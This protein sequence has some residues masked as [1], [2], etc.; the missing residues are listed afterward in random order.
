MSET[1]RAAAKLVALEPTLHAQ[2]A[3]GLPFAQSVWMN[4]RSVVFVFTPITDIEDLNTAYIVSFAESDELRFRLEEAIWIGIGLGAM[5][6][7][8]W[9]LLLNWIRV[10]R[11]KEASLQFLENINDAM[12]EG[13]YVVD[14]NGR[15]MVINA[16]ALA[17]L[18]LKESD[19]I[20]RLALNLFLPNLDASLLETA[21]E[22]E[23]RELLNS[24]VEMESLCYSEKAFEGD[25]L[26]AT[27][28]GKKFWVHLSSQPIYM[29]RKFVGKVLVFHDITVEKS[30]KEQLRVAAAAFETHEGI[31]ITDAKMNIIRVNKAFTILTGY[32]PEDIIGKTPAALSSGR[33]DKAFYQAMWSTLD[34]EKAWQGEIWNR[35]KNGDFFLESLKITAVTNADGNV[36]EY[37][38][39]FSDITEQ[40]KAQDEII[41][42]A[43]YD[44]LTLLPNR[45]LLNE[46]LSHALVTSERN[47][48]YGAL[49]FI[50]LDNFKQLNDTRGHSAGDAL[51]E[52]VAKRLT[53]T[54]RDVDTVARL[55]GDE[56]VILLESL[57]STSLEA[58]TAVELLVFKILHAFEEVFCLDSGEQ[59]STPSLGV[60]IF[61]GLTL[62]AEQV[63]QH[64]DVAMYQAKQSGRNTACY[65]DPEMQRHIENVLQI[66]SDL[67][68]DQAQGF[69]QLRLYYQPQVD[70]QGNTRSVEALIRWV[71]PQKGLIPPLEFI[72]IIEQNGQIIAVGLWVIREACLQLA[73][74][75]QNPAT[76][77]LAI[78]VN[79]SAKQLAYADFITQ[80]RTVLEET[81]ARPSHL[82]IELT[83]SSVIENVEAVIKV[84]QE[85]CA[86]G[87]ELSM[88]D[89][90][91]GYSSLSYLKRLPLSQLKIDQAFVRD[92]ET[93]MDSL[94]IVQTIIAMAKTLKLIV[95]AEGVETEGQ[96]KCLEA[97]GCELYQGYYFSR[98]LPLDALEEH[99]GLTGH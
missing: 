87:L 58:M 48:N 77:H 57:G 25:Y 41:R 72:P 68:K 23:R 43:F 51:L 1:M 86:L 24:R 13:M 66:E 27:A 70:Y 67:H 49:I 10:S 18:E 91:T 54:V 17:F 20:G 84:M 6:L 42:L 4:Q 74:W 90:G 89:F 62:T 52:E 96:R 73:K 12:S 97:N 32:T 40:K 93:D 60:E 46:R 35:R 28:S 82:K 75:A 79:V 69:Q 99:M 63:L 98:P 3:K 38:A 71:H 16:S 30:H 92:L 37:V 39:I 78:A 80:L 55:G 88:D 47:K 94:A 61:Q 11:A 36:T 65:F 44:S 7:V 29:K 56:F 21:S 5:M 64:A 26:F 76:E 14:K 19:A 31:L 53:Q 33:Q 50:D 9:V 15:L 85:M 8:L 22:T 83:E 81:G 2:L 45:R 59:R 95:I 34:Q